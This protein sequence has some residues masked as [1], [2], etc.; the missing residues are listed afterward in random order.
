LL[1]LTVISFLFTATSQA[2]EALRIVSWNMRATLHESMKTRH[3]DFARLN[4]QLRPDVLI[5]IEV[6]GAEE[7]KSAAEA[8]GW[9]DYQAVV[10][11]WNLAE[12]SAFQALEVAVI[13]KKKILSA[14]EFDAPEADGVAAAFGAGALANAL[15]AISERP[16]TN[17]LL[18]PSARSRRA[19]AARSASTWT[20]GLTIFPVHLKSNSNSACAEVDDARSTIR[21]QDRDVAAKLDSYFNEGFRKATDEHLENA[22]KRERMMAAVLNEANQVPAERAVLIAGDFNTAFEENKFGVK[23][24]VDC[25]LRDY[26][27]KNAPFPRGACSTGN[28]GDGF[29]DTLSILERGLIGGKTWTFLT[30]S[31]GRTYRNREFADLAIDHMAVPADQVALFT[32]A[33]KSDPES[34]SS[35]HFAVATEFRRVEAKSRV[36]LIIAGR[37]VELVRIAPPRSGHQAQV[38]DDPEDTSALPQQPWKSQRAGVQ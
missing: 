26:N 5:L 16:L 10:S 6:A 2:Q 19:T 27:C 4:E 9:T 38:G 12:N 11:A 25:R 20:S 1:Y 31:L 30:R 18:Q 33:S 13:S 24:D 28:D 22:R 37:S 17:T 21:T 32:A 23:L 14:V 36:T 3:A 7:A 29:D 15:P 8:L 34:F 35:D